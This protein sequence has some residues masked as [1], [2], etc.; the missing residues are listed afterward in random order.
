MASHCVCGAHG[1][2]RPAART[3]WC[4][5]PQQRLG[6]ASAVD[7]IDAV[8]ANGTD[9]VALEVQGSGRRLF[10]IMHLATGRAQRPA[11]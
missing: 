1:R 10:Q 7:V 3:V 9:R 4:L 11:G 6:N 5:V 2:C 8:L